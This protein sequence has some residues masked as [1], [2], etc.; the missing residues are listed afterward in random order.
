MG[1]VGETPKN[2][3]NHSERIHQSIE[4]LETGR[5]Q[6]PGPSKRQPH[7]TKCAPMKVPELFSSHIEETLA[8][9]PI[10]FIGENLQAVAV[11]FFG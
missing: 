2:C 5:L 8:K 4:D 3:E 6:N 11:F 10:V 9:K 1:E 7:L